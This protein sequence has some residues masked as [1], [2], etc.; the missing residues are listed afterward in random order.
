MYL[1]NSGEYGYNA[2]GLDKAWNDFKLKI[3]NIEYAKPIENSLK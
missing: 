3:F 2:I 1:A